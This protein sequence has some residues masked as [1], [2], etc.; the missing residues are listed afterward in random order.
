M[1]IKGKKFL[2]VGLG[3]TGVSATRFILAQGGKVTI[4]D[5]RTRMELAESIKLLGDL[6]VEMDLGKHN[7]KL[8]TQNDVIVLSPGVPGNIEGLSEARAAGIPIV[9]DIEIA[10]HFI[11]APIIA[12]TGTNGKTTTTTLIGEMLRNEGKKVFVGGNIGVSALDMLINGETP[13]AV[14]LEVS[15]FQLESMENFKPSIVVLTNLEP[16][17]LDRYPTGV[18]SYYAA[19]QRILKNADKSTTL[20]LNL[21]NER[22]LQWAEQFPGKVLHFTKRDPMTI[23]PQLAEKFK[24]A[25]LRRPKVVLKGFEK[26]NGEEIIEMILC[27]L[28]GDHNRENVMAAA[29]AARAFGATKTS[30]QKTIDFFKGVPHRLEFLR[31]KDNVAFYNDSKATNVASVLRSLSSFNA[32]VILIMG[33]RDKDQ[34]FT[35]LMELVKKRVKNLILVG[36]AK[37]KINRILGDFSETF[38]VGTFEEAVLIGFQKSRNGDIVLLAPGCAS[39]DMFRNYEE[40][41]DYFKKMVSQL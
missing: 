14:V 17:H 12:V 33:G 5:S 20:I 32:P 41:G 11:K 9:N 19:K 35:P 13:D 38:L 40:R 25:Y 27:K 29:L 26:G 15:S 2:V 37:E 10:T 39:Y 28:P 34:D 1:K 22:S 31:K 4:T 30:I 3:K 23:S 21:D 8:F 36:E 18:E 7:P 24:G 16:D 6:K